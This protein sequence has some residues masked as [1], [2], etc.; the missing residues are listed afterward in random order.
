VVA[1]VRRVAI[2]TGSEGT[3][4]NLQSPSLAPA[5]NPWRDEDAAPTLV[6]ELPRDADVE[7]AAS[8]ANERHLLLAIRRAAHLRESLPSRPVSS[9]RENQGT[10]LCSLA[11]GME[12]ADF[13]LVKELGAGAFAKVFLAFHES[14]Q[15]VVA[16][17]FSTRPSHEPKLLSALDHRH[18]VRVYHYDDQCLAEK[19]IHVLFMEY[20]S[21]VD[22]KRLLRD[23]ASVPI[24]QRS[25]AWLAN[26]LAQTSD[27]SAWRERLTL[28]PHLARATWAEVV[29]SISARIADALAYAHRQSVVHR[30][31][32]PANVL[33]RADGSP[34]LVDFN[35]GFG[36]HVLGARPEDCFGG[37][38]AY[39]APEQ[40]SAFD[41]QSDTTLL[42]NR[43]DI[44]SLG[45]LLH[46]LLTGSLPALAGKA[47]P[48]SGDRRGKSTEGQLESCPAGLRDIVRRC[49]AVEAT[50][51]PSAD[52]VAGRLR[53]CSSAE[54][55]DFVYARA[56]SW[57]A[58]ALRHPLVALLA[59]VL[60]PNA[61]FAVLNILFVDQFVS[62]GFYNDVPPHWKLQIGYYRFQEIVVNGIVF[63]LGMYFVALLARPVVRGLPLDSD[64]PSDNSRV[65]VAIAERAAAWERAARLG[66]YVWAVAL[67]FWV[68]TGIIF[69]AWNRLAQSHYTLN[70]LSWHDFAAFF[71]TQVAFGAMASALSVL[72]VNFVLTRW[73]LPA[74]VR[75]NPVPSA[76]G[77]DPIAQQ[78]QRMVHWLAFVPQFS[79]LAVAA[80][81][82]EHATLLVTL[83]LVSG[84]S[85]GCGIFYARS[86]RRAAARLRKLLSPIDD[87]LDD[88]RP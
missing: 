1:A 38:P 39:M 40:Q 74:L 51:R 70:R 86:I 41:Q 76:S 72:G 60:A 65:N 15:R 37:S 10:G 84:T 71:M 45:V 69:A 62:D 20:V 87:P 63:P 52:S 54:M 82:G 59:V 55:H 28:P 11:P 18:I 24:P 27:D 34:M 25:G 9:G 56:G 3:L 79:L 88:A 36:E 80:F 2:H 46:E 50:D 13:R 23:V 30:D 61:F 43:C 35:V 53:I 66:F 4:L 16:I 31:V 29:A 64:L 19:G 85:Y 78:V 32:K 5:V 81:I 33:L 22:L 75:D 17:K 14:M 49:L 73:L 42:D 68:G 47:S 77:I 58:T 7:S 8:L 6:R 67:G 83:G 21:G 26:Y 57:A 48:E 12:L 44:Y